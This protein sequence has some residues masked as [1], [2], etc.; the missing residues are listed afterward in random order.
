MNDRSLQRKAERA[1]HRV[2]PDIEISV[3]HGIVQLDGRVS[4]HEKYLEAGRAAGR[5]TGIRGVVNDLV[6]P[7]KP[8]MRELEGNTETIATAD[9]VIIGG[10]VTG[11]IIARELSRYDL[12]VILVEKEPD[13]ACGTTKANN[14]MVHTG[15]G[16]KMGTLKQQLC[17]EGHRL[18]PR[19][20]QELDVPYRQCGMWI[21]L[22][23]ES[24]TDLPIPDWLTTPIGKHLV[25]WILLRRA[26][27]LGLYM[28]QVSID[29]VKQR[30]PNITDDVTAAVF[31]PT[32][33]VTC[34]YRLT[35]ALAENAVENGVD[36]RLDTAVT[37]IEAT[38]GRVTAVVTTKGRIETSWIIN[39]AGLHA[40]RI[41]AMA[42]AREYTIHPK[43]GAI[44]LFDSRLRG[45]VNHCM[46]LLR[47]PRTEHYKGGGVMVTADGNIQ[48]GPTMTETPHQDDTAVTA[49]D[50]ETIF[51]K[52]RP[53]LPDFPTGDVIAYFSGLRA[54][55][56]TEDFIIRPADAV[57]G[58]IHVAGIQS[59][60]LAAAPAIAARVIS[61]LREQGL[62]L[63]EKP[64]FNPRRHRPPPFWE[65]SHEERQRR[66]EQ[67]ERYGHV[68]CRCEHVSEGD[69]IDALHRPI[70]VHTIDAVKRRT[71]A[72]MGRCQGGFCLPKVARIIARELDL[73]L[74]EVHKNGDGSYLFV[75]RAK[76]L[77]EAD[78]AD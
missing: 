19:L 35:I 72:G 32:Y 31:S 62:G 37:D 55:T 9:V 60:G 16:E 33:G 67:D 69:I 18:Y 78:Y 28:E 45:Y 2:Q 54:C 76:S 22:T 75:G 71:R 51:E 63:P 4:S 68:V 21:V 74:E 24:F 14:A 12:D 6:Y 47:F 10:G 66:I 77:L 5:I 48:W 65:S 36:I 1:V 53:L 29:E 57:D 11:C 17:V 39:A 25:P 56:F 41:A 7:G 44:A 52:Y 59:P 73:P 3:E 43:R 58:F 70:P 50:L 46:S 20:C 26:K 61:I 27:K 8:D 64:G 34:P 38:D 42:G 15:I 23:S 40:D 49:E 30:E 13:V